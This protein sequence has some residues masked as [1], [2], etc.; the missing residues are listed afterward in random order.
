MQGGDGSYCPLKELWW[1]MG[2]FDSTAFLVTLA[3]A[4]RVISQYTLCGIQETPEAITYYTK[5]VRSL[6]R[7]IESLEDRLSE[8]VIVAVLEFAYYDVSKC[9]QLNFKSILGTD[10]SVKFVSQ[11]LQRWLI[12][13][14][15]F[16]A[17]IN[18]RGGIQS[19]KS[20]YMIQLLCF[21]SAIP[22]I[23]RKYCFLILIYRIDVSGSFIFD[24]KPF[25]EPP[26]HLLHDVK[27]KSPPSPLL[28]KYI[29]RF[30]ELSKITTFLSETANLTTFIDEHFNGSRVMEDDKFLSKT[31]NIYVH[32]LLSLPR[33]DYSGTDL[34]SPHLI[35][36]E[37]AR[38]AC[39][40]LFALLRERFSIIP[41]G[42]YE[43][44]NLLKEILLQHDVDWTP[45]LE[46][47]LWVLAIATLAADGEEIQWYVDEICG[48]ATQMGLL[49]WD[50]VLGVL[51]QTLWMEPTF[52]D[53][54]NRMRGMFELSNSL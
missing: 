40:I 48:T 15:G 38:R 53:E 43:H 16:H 5:S 36:Q 18:R 34:F 17:I 35:V 47:R 12:H 39:M 21:W 52:K 30:P 44:K 41:S 45:Y 13:M 2:L 8:G 42:L 50:E 6:Q 22:R 23:S 54:E 49:D 46:L 25:F 7:R 27:D 3:N 20:S 11:N 51:Q 31:F 28:Q 32:K 1:N 37:A 14:N 24:R 4:S 19:L 9:L 26:H 29:N 33:L 10:G